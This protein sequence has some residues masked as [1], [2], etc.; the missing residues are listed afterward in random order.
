M[1]SAGLGAAAALHS[2]RGPGRAPARDPARAR[3]HADP[4]DLAHV[5]GRLVGRAS[6]P[7]RSVSP[8]Y[9]GYGGAMRIGPGAVRA[10]LLACLI[11]VLAPVLAAP[12]AGASPAP[13]RHVVVVG[14]S[15]LRWSDVPGAAVALGAGTGHVASSLPSPW[16]LSA[17]VLARCPLTVGDLG[18][19]GCADRAG[20]LAAA[21]AEL[22]RIAAEPPADPPLLVPA[23]GATAKPP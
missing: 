5:P 8:V 18:S 11:A 4:V 2:S 14:L 10:I 7:A 9:P 6:H 19:P 1:E 15:G 13:A 23:P 21:D 22:A 17:A 20:Q 16:G 12:S 3:V